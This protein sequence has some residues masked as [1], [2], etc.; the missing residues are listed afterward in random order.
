MSTP[1]FQG[2]IESIAFGGEGVLKT[3]GHVVFIPYTAPGDEIEYE[4]VMKKKRF[5]RGEILKI[6][7]P[8]PERTLPLCPYY[9]NC[10]GCQL[11]H[12]R[13]SG[14]QASKK[15]MVEDALKRIGKFS[16]PAV[17]FEQDPALR[18]WAYR[19]RV[20]FHLSQGEI[21]YIA[22]DNRSIVE[23]D[24]CPIFLE[25]KHS[26]FKELRGLARFF[27]AAG[28]VDV[29]KDHSGKFLVYVRLEHYD[30]Q[31]KEALEWG[32]MNMP[33]VSG[34]EIDRV[35]NWG[36]EIIVT[37]FEG[38]VIEYS[39]RVFIQSNKAVSEKIYQEIGLIL[40]GQ[41]SCLDLYSGI[42]ITS[43]LMAKQGSQVVA[44]ES[45]GAAVNFAKNNAKKN[46]LKNVEFLGGGVE[47]LLPKVL[48]DH[49]FDAAVI[50]PPREGLYPEIAEA[51][52]KSGI[53]TLVYVSCMP[54]TL[55][56][57]AH[58]LA[59]G[60]YKV[61]RVKAYDMFPQTGHIETLMVLSL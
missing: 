61:T 15:I 28:R 17:E 59:E 45:N 13:Y 32:H 20:A 43:M 38:L 51:L 14:Q 27:T 7:N 35:G 52:K 31:C 40:E 3:D 12:I 53:K 39:P 55:A 29:L 21:G 9:Q 57:D 4:I 47:S 33:S 18:P 46:G 23:V 44:I 37:E 10:G 56:R 41:K 58:I 6:I 1:N 48:K 8:S 2:K 5:A 60:G 30:K 54:S 26:L 50:N 11:Q 22:L 25:G 34:L 19:E 42:G 24:E 36:K 49:S 16:F